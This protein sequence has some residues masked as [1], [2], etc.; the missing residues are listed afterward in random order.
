M[1][2]PDVNVLLNAYFIEQPGHRVARD[3]LARAL[4]G[5][6][7]VAVPDLVLTGFVRISTSRV[8]RRPLTMA[9]AFDACEQVRTAPAHIVLPPL[10]EHW[11]IYRRFA[12][13]HARTGGDFTDAY[14]AA[15]AVANKAQLVSFDKGFARSEQLQW[16]R[17]G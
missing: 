3:W 4:N 13:A 16:L 14:L 1:L 11:T 9:H 10:D 2:L 17:L 12:E 8:F 6:E 15:L 7:A 5:S